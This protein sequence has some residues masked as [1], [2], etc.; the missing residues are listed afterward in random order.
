MTTVTQAVDRALGWVLVALMSIAVLN[1]LWQVFTRFVLAD[2]SRFTDE[3]ARYL[4]IW[5]GLLGA[6]Y[7][8]GGHMHLAI[9]LLPSRLTG[10]RR[11]Y[12]SVLIEAS[13]FLVAL[14]VLVI[15]GVRLVTLTLTLGQTSAALHVPLG[16]V[17]VAL[18]LSGLLM[19]FFSVGAVGRHYAELHGSTEP[20]VKSPE[21]H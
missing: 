19:M 14:S 11:F 13:V 16:Y 9:D 12:L 2:P 5:I 8:V 7:A 18:P 20:A 4:L 10:R 21:L 1:V 15:G 6:S 17:Y 3:L